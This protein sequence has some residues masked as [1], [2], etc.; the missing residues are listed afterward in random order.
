MKTPTESRPHRFP[1]HRRLLPLAAVGVL[2]AVALAGLSFWRLQTSPAFVEVPP[3]AILG[4]RSDMSQA[5]GDVVLDYGDPAHKAD[6]QR[7]AKGE[8]LN[9]EFVE[10]ASTEEV[11]RHGLAGWPK[12]QDPP[13]GTRVPKGTTVRL[14]VITDTP[15][16]E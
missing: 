4:G 14:T 15:I 8:G 7:I 2:V 5:V 13:A 1:G 16:T 11:F 3:L 10:F 6:F 12:G 9:V